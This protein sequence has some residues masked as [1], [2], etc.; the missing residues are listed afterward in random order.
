MLPYNKFVHIMKI[1]TLSHKLKSNNM[2]IEICN[3]NKKH[4]M[5]INI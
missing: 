3:K 4:N 5:H 1:K 2:K